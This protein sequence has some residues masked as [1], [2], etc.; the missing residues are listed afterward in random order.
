[1]SQPEG[2]AVR[3]AF[4]D[5]DG[6]LLDCSS[7]RLFLSHLARTGG[8]GFRSALRFLAGYAIHPGRTRHF[9]PGWNRGYLEGMR[10]DVAESIAERF[11]RETLTSRI[12]PEVRRLLAGLSAEGFRIVLLSASLSFLVDPLRVEA[13]AEEAICS[14]P[15]DMDGVLTGRLAGDR[16]WGSSKAELAARYASAA[17]SPLADCCALGDSDSDI[18]LLSSCG[19]AIAV[20]PSAGLRRAAARR[21]WKVIEGR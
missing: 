19:S 1:M 15:E 20:H 17:G 9:G 5:V 4:V 14:V 12:R 7:E 3:L 2:A 13:G 8:I 18:P 10:R 11:A 6:T 21:G 16:P